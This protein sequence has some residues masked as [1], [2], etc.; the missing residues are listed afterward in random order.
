M[1]W[2]GTTE[3]WDR[4][5][6]WPGTTECCGGHMVWPGTTECYHDRRKVRS[7]QLESTVTGSVSELAVVVVS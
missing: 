5:M 3:C 7:E 1:V 6:V 4:H 2:P